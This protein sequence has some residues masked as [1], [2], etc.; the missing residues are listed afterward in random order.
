MKPLPL[1]LRLAAGIAVS[2]FETARELPTKLVE[3]P[4]TVASQAMQA[5]M[6][7]QQQV[8][9]LAIK[10][11]EVLAVLRPVEETPDWARFDEDLADDLPA[12]STDAPWSRFDA[13]EDDDLRATPRETDGNGAALDP[14]TQEERAFAAAAVGDDDLED[15]AD[16]A[17][18]RTE[19]PADEP[20]DAVSN[21]TE[22]PVT[23]AA[24]TGTDTAGSPAAPAG[25]TNYAE[26]SLP[27]IR[28]RL[29]TFTVEQLT[30]L[31]D[32]ER[33]TANRP[34]FVG[35]LSR[36]IDTVRDSG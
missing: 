12:T 10:G 33:A 3:L 34:A 20:A 26:L 1:P 29:R 25:L 36:R 24:D 14:W 16:F 19:D 30:E 27:Q 21:A 8:T 4:I 6:R 7:L 17:D 15:G 9:A 22:T 35:M 32:H 13:I 5:S 23:A 31:L 28:A 11:D 18:D 2:A